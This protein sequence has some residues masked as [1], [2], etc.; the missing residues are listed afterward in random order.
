MKTKYAVALLTMVMSVG[1][2]AQENDDMYFNTKDRNVVNKANEIVLA[3]RYQQEDINAVRTNPVN[4]S[5]SYSGRGVNPEY[6]AQS[7]NGTTVVQNNPDYFLAGYQP[8]NVNGS[9]YSGGA[10]AYSNPYCGN[11]AYNNYYGNMGYGG[12]GMGSRSMFGMGYGSMMGMG[13]GGYS[14]FYNPYSSFYSPYSIFSMSYG[15]G[16][17]FGS[18]YGM[19]GSGYGMGMYGMNYMY[20]PYTYGAYGNSYGGQ[21]VINGG[22]SR[23]TVNGRHPSRSSGLNNYVDNTRNDA[24]IIGTNGRVREGGRVSTNSAS[25][26]YYDR[27]WRSNSSNFSNTNGNWNNGGNTRSGWGNNNSSWGNSGGATRSSFDSFGSGSRG[28]FGGGGSSSGGGS[29]GGHSRGKN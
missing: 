26:D 12:M 27:G 7:K 1:A 11:S 23:A 8:K 21:A 14:S 4:P 10:S 29:S 28:S 5:D 9:L 15:A 13:Y 18:P 25:P 3:K 19:Y 22:D 2:M 24:T 16:S 17:M 6:N 20:N